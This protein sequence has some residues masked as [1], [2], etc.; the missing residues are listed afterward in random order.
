MYV[1]VVESKGYRHL[2]DRIG[3][4]A[5]G[6]YKVYNKSIKAH[7]HTHTHTYTVHYELLALVVNRTALSH[8]YCSVTVS[9]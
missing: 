4:S 9:F 7:T 8:S 1:F 2:S 5:Q 3:R 6:R